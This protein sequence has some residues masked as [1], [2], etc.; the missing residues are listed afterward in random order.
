MIVQAR[1]R[2][3]IENFEDSMNN[4]SSGAKEK[5]VDSGVTR[6]TF[7]G[8]SLASGATLLAGEPGA[9]FGRLI[10]DIEPGH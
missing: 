7:L 10:N 9:I 5:R 2:R 8:M 3:G 4:H 6:R 1:L